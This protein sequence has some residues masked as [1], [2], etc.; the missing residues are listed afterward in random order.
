MPTRLIANRAEKSGLGVSTQGFESLTDTKVLEN[1]TE[2]GQ[3]GIKRPT[4]SK[5]F[6]F[7]THAQAPVSSEQWD[8]FNP[9]AQ[10]P[11]RKVVG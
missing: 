1:Q 6:E 5:I 3:P 10:F 7:L 2:Q 4:G 9:G 11:D 8:Q